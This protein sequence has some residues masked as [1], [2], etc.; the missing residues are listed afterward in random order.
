M[1]TIS[2]NQI[3]T[4]DL[5]ARCL[6][7]GLSGK[8]EK[9]GLSGDMQVTKKDMLREAQQL[10]DQ[11]RVTSA[12]AIYRR[13]VDEDPSD[14]NAISM[15]GALYEKAG[16][17]NDAVEHFLRIAEKFLKAGSAVSGAYILK[18]VIR[19]DPTNAVANMNLGELQL[20]EKAAG[21]AHDH[22]IEA[23]AAFWHKGNIP[24]AIKMNK[25]ALEVMPDSRHAKAALALIQRETEPP[26]PP[27]PKKREI[28]SD[29]PEIIISIADGSDD[30]CAPLTYFEQ[31]KAVSNSG[32]L[33][34]IATGDAS[35]KGEDTI[36][37]QIAMAE[38]LVGCGHLDQ[39]IRSLREVLLEKPDH[40]QIRE[41]LKDIYLRSE[42]MDR[43]SEECV[44]IAAVYVARGDHGRAADYIAR[45]R[46]FNPSMEDLSSV[47]SPESHGAP[48]EVTETSNER[49]TGGLAFTVM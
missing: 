14:L 4:S 43:A 46:L 6:L 3:D 15:L 7:E 8:F 21:A 49:Q 26:A 38:Y 9:A 13:I 17:S 36:I 30:V 16:R 11:G 20:Q 12:I 47:A 10:I 44:N 25:R 33:N 37:Q 35:I 27:E 5:M 22:F 19:I 1:R 41:K 2:C 31:P 28:T 39:A 18:K 34:P 42:M 32:P 24:A 29:L 23:A 45:A 40:I 48:T